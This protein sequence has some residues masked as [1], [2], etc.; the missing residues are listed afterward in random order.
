MD[1]EDMQYN[2]RLFSH[3]L[4]RFFHTSRFNWLKSVILKHKINIY[5][6][7]EIGCFDARSLTYFQDMPSK[8]WGFD[9]GWEGGLDEAKKT[10]ANFNN[11]YFIESN[12][13]SDLLK[14]VDTK[15]CLTI[16]LETLEHINPAE[17]PDYLS[18]VSEIT[19][20]FFFSYGS[21][22]KRYF[23][24]SKVPFEKVVLWWS[25]RLYIVRNIMGY[26]RKN[27]KGSAKSPQRV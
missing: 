6:V 15:S 11:Y 18:A 3:G 20:G 19:D 2:D 25:L 27:E 24:F 23:I 16:A 10:F 22:R 5:S 26:A 7:V 9:A 8:Y 12:S 14:F 17:V 1:H 4:R 13:A 21:Q